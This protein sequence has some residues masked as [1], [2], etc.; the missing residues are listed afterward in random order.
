MLQGIARTFTVQW[1]APSLSAESNAVFVTEAATPDSFYG[2]LVR[3][4]IFSE[5]V[6][7]LPK[8][9]LTECFRQCNVAL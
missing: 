6:E 8:V 2:F 4:T 9:L 1:V 5:K 3:E 7:T